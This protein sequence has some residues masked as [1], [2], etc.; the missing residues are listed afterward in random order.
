MPAAATPSPRVFKLSPEL[1]GELREAVADIER[2]DYLALTP[3]QLKEWAEKGEL[4]V[5][6][7]WLAG[8]HA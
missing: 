8:S 1:E 6:D 2:G 7:E 3:E 5:L 4:R